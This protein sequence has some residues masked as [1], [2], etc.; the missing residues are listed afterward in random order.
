MTRPRVLLLDEPLSALDK[1]LRVD[2]QVELRRIQRDVAITTVFVTHDQ[3]EALTLSDRVGILRDGQL[4]QEGTARELYDQ[5][6]SEFAA[7]F[8]GDANILTGRLETGGMRINDG[9]LI[10]FGS[11][12]A[13][14]NQTKCAVRPEKIVLQ[15][16]TGEAAHSTHNRLTA[17]VAHH[18]FAGVNTTYMLD[19]CGQRLKV[20][21]Q[22][23]GED[24]IPVGS[25][26]TLSW[27]PDSTILVH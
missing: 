14:S 17:Q 21:V 6:A 16:A 2:M 25:Q 10:R 1:S 9:S 8:L 18:V 4:I 23:S 26:V 5:P 13:V 19:W 24:L 7:T 15:R 11:R 27:S 3:E 12:S 22:N 20:H